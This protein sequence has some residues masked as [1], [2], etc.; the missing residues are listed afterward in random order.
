MIGFI[1]TSSCMSSRRCF[2]AIWGNCNGGFP[3]PRAQLRLW[4]KRWQVWRRKTSTKVPT[5]PRANESSAIFPSTRKRKYGSALLPLLRS[6]CQHCGSCVCIST[7]GFASWKDWVSHWSASA[8]LPSAGG[9]KLTEL[10][11]RVGGGEWPDPRIRTAIPWTQQSRTDACTK[12]LSNSVYGV[13]ESSRLVHGIGTPSRCL[14]IPDTFFGQA[15]TDSPGAT[16]PPG[17]ERNERRSP[18]GQQKP[19][20]DIAKGS[21]QQ[22]ESHFKLTYYSS[23]LKTRSRPVSFLPMSSLLDE[24]RQVVLHDVAGCGR[25]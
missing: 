13:A 14:L 23:S 20:M 21:R 16:I 4:R 19:G 1:P 8:L 2:T 9:I 22:R 6:D 15:K 18:E 7:S 25:S 12:A 24:L 17:A 10:D 11:P 3:D 5:R